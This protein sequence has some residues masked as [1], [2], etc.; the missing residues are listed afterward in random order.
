M[1]EDKAF[2]VIILGGG[3][4]GKS[5]ILHRFVNQSFEGENITS[6]SKSEY[7][8]VIHVANDYNEEVQ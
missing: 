7:V 3:R 5:S 1:I 6:R 2:K 4:V 8:K